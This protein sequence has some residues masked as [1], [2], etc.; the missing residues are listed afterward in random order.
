MTDQELTEIK[1]DLKEIK[2]MMQI[3]SKQVAA[4]QEVAAVRTLRKL[5]ESRISKQIRQMS[6]L[7][8]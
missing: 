2:E 6:E 5:E 3:I 4:D 1:S 7:A 8:D